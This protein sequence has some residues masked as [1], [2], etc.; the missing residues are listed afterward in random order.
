MIILQGF[1]L[2]FFTQID[3]P[4]R[5]F[6]ENLIIKYLIG[7]KNVK[8][9]L[10]VQLPRPSVPAVKFEGYWVVEGSLPPS[11]NKGYILTPSV[12]ANLKD[13]ARAVSAG[14]IMHTLLFLVK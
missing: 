3:N 14:Y 6:V 10:K 12:R 13:I 8:S 2:S 4:S 7:K 1:C 11:V 5:P 9:M